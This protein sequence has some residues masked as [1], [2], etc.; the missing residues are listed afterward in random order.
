MD[1]KV[2]AMVG[3]VIVVG[4]AV[5]GVATGT[6]LPG[7]EDITGGADD[8]QQED[9]DSVEVGDLDTDEDDDGDG[10]NEGGDENDV[11]DGNDE[12]GADAD[13]EDTNGE[14]ADGNG[15]E[16]NGEEEDI[17]EAPIDLG[18][19]E[20]SPYICEERGGNVDVSDISDYRPIA[21][22]PPFDALKFESMLHDSLN[23]LREIR[24]DSPF[25]ETELL[26][27]D[28]ELR[29]IARE[30]SRTGDTATVR[31]EA[32]EICENPQVRQG[33]WYYQ[34][35]MELN[36]PSDSGD[37]RVVFIANHEDL[38]R[39]IR[40]AWGNDRS[41]VRTIIDEEMT[42]QGIGADIDRRSRAVVVTQVVCGD[43][44]EEDDEDDEG[45]SDDE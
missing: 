26:R 15:D 42:R 35:D 7:T 22:G 12:N 28:P 29:D 17:D 43:L 34:R 38:V 40:G 6:V 8:T 5:Y 45:D 18:L 11:G 21:A 39:D 31:N 16:E 23:T 10:G 14:G 27:C 9:D 1:T 32:Q 33:L 2:I 36:S 41:F 3:A 20:D 4:A 19:D 13:G 30:G 24:T 37:Q 25:G 44:E